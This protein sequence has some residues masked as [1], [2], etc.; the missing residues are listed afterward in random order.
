MRRISLLTA[1]IAVTALIVAPGASAKSQ[2]RRLLL[3]ADRQ[4]D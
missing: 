3:H 4:L 2:R 1:A